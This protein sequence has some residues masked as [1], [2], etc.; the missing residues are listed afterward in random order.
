MENK[1]YQLLYGNTGNGYGII[2]C[3]EDME[4]DL[5]YLL[6]DEA[7]QNKLF[8]DT[9]HR[10][11]HYAMRTVLNRGMLSFVSTMY[12]PFHGN[13]GRA[14]NYYHTI[15]AQLPVEEVF[16]STDTFSKM[17]NLSYCTNDDMI[18]VLRNPGRASSF[19]KNEPEERVAYGAPD[20]FLFGSYE[21]EIREIVTRLYCKS[22]A[23][24]VLSG[25]PDESLRE[26]ANALLRYIYKY[27]SYTLRND[28]SFII[29]CNED[30]FD[31]ANY[32][33]MIIS[34]SG[35]STRSPYYDRIVIDLG[36]GYAEQSY[37]SRYSS[38]EYYERDFI[39]YVLNYSD[40]VSR[41]F[42]NFQ[43]FVGVHEGSYQGI[44]SIV[45]FYE[46][47]SEFNDK[48]SSAMDGIDSSLQSLLSYAETQRWMYDEYYD[49]CRRSG[50]DPIFDAAIFDKTQYSGEQLY[51]EEYFGICR[52]FIKAVLD[53]AS[54]SDAVDALDI[55]A[56]R[57][58]LCS[59]ENSAA[60]DKATLIYGT[61]AVASWLQDAAQA[62]DGKLDSFVAPIND[63]SGRESAQN[64]VVIINDI[65]ASYEAELHESQPS[66][67]CS[68]AWVLMLSTPMNA[69]NTLKSKL[70]SAIALFDT[71]QAK[72]DREE[73]DVRATQQQ[74]KKA[75][76]KR[77][78]QA[79]EADAARTAELKAQIARMKESF[80][81]ELDTVK[82]YLWT[83]VFS[84]YGN[85]DIGTLSVGSEEIFNQEVVSQ[86]K[87]R[88]SEML[89]V[90]SALQRLWAEDEVVCD[91]D[92]FPVSLEVFDEWISGRSSGDGETIVLN[93]LNALKNNDR[94]TTPLAEYNAYF[95][96]MV[97]FPLLAE[98][99]LVNE[100][101]RSATISSIKSS[102][103]GYLEDEIPG[104][105]YTEILSMFKEQS[106]LYESSALYIPKQHSVNAT[107]E[108]I[109]AELVNVLSTDE[110]SHNFEYLLLGVIDVVLGDGAVI[111]AK[112]SELLDRKKRIYK[113]EGNAISNF[114]KSKNTK[115]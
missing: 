4:S 97:R 40:D 59:D 112:A 42:V 81:T 53:A 31:H 1:Y 28:F 64:Q 33:L 76:E 22:N 83:N 89:S 58:I 5:Q 96:A 66:D 85:D 60:L 71:E 44:K 51:R 84:G 24:V 80:Y 2:S 30:D 9:R 70:E 98:N 49:H 19:C 63:E 7:S 52:S 72:R 111:H 78:E 18:E 34:D 105:I 20:E 101:Y 88:Q 109:A 48:L 95:K 87:Y 75:E 114:A 104:V 68:E 12:A 6:E 36:G 82:R 46:N 74:I 115:K 43:T 15:C 39:D 93:A 77:N 11:N 3:T 29:G 10:F 38:L 102:C 56:A 14:Q 37:S 103:N 86:L 8:N 100:A 26:Y 21:E 16:G 35:C 113:M 47:Q 17:L 41:F 45:D 67:R 57:E 69:L 32:S 106:D 94:E 62:F 73:A 108:A 91:V 107:L 25:I 92:G 61:T 27:L 55:V 13:L 54:L 110:V 50:I 99:E 90:I 79:R 65:L 23:L